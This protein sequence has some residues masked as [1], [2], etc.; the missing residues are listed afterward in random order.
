MRSVVKLYYSITMI[1]ISLQE[2]LKNGYH[3]VRDKQIKPNGLVLSAFCNALCDKH[4]HTESI[5][6]A[7]PKGSRG[8]ELLSEMACSIDFGGKS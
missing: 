8:R 6:T 1:P 7:L 3:R 4:R 2:K 5:F